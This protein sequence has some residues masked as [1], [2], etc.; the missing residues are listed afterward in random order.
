LKT[1]K[2]YWLIVLIAL[3]ALFNLYPRPSRAFL[4][5]TIPQL[6]GHTQNLIGSSTTLFLDPSF[7]YRFS[8]NEQDFI[9][10]MQQL[11][12]EPVDASRYEYFQDTVFALHGPFFWHNWWW[13]PVVNQQVWLFDGYQGGNN[14]TFLYIPEKQRVF[15]YIQNT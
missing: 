1:L 13:Q 2:K 6:N 15:L 8:M 14:V 12:L 7:Y 11:A 10:L 4:Y 5:R 9:Q 3:V